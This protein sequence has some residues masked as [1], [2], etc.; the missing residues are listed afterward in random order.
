MSAAREV[1][2]EPTRTPAARTS[3][4][5]APTLRPKWQSR[6]NACFKSSLALDGVLAT[7]RWTKRSSN[8]YQLNSDFRG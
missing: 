1:T 8:G 2:S 7:R 3:S 6:K 5:A 4:P